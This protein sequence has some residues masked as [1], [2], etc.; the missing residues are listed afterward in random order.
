[1]FSKTRKIT[2]DDIMSKIDS[3]SKQF[4]NIDK[5]SKIT[6]SLKYEIE[7]LNKIKKNLIPL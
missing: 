3:L 1:M 4:N 6:Q 2:N 7:E 5:L